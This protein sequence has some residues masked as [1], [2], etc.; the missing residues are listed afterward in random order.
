MSTVC[1]IPIFL[2]KSTLVY[3][4]L[5]MNFVY[6]STSVEQR[7]SPSWLRVPTT[8]RRSVGH[9]EADPPFSLCWP[10]SLCVLHSIQCSSPPTWFVS[11][12]WWIKL[13]EEEVGITYDYSRRGV[14]S[15]GIAWEPNLSFTTKLLPP[16][17]YW[18][19]HSFYLTNSNTNTH[20]NTDRNK[21]QIKIWH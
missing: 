21:K 2:H 3:S 11:A 19:Q 13:Y 12:V 4:G 8:K 14:F 16:Q 18:H 9:P 17:Q 20:A 7:C 15:A 1:F 5:T 10:S 6:A